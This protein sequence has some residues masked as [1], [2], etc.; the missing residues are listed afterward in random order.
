[1]YLQITHEKASFTKADETGN[2]NRER[3]IVKVERFSHY[4]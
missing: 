3:I 1:M 4:R 2:V